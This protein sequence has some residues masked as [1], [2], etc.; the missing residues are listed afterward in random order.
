MK[1]KKR[2]INVVWQDLQSV[3]SSGFCFFCLIPEDGAKWQSVCGPDKL[4]IGTTEQNPFPVKARL[5][6]LKGSHCQGWL[7]RQSCFLQIY[8]FLHVTTVLQLFEMKGGQLEQGQKAYDFRKLNEGE[9]TPHQTSPQTKRKLYLWLAASQTYLVAS[10]NRFDSL[11]Y[12]SP[13]ACMLFTV[14]KS[15]WGK[16]EW[17]AFCKYVENE[18]HALSSHFMIPC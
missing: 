8:I 9:K 3:S 10:K 11:T 14:T 13:S 5:V 16:L 4:H 1:N 2:P 6:S 18:K 17:R 15:L 7:G 12:Y